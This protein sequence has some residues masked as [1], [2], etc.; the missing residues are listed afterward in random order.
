MKK[1]NVDFK[2]LITIWVILA[3][4]L[5]LN[6]AHY[7]QLI[8]DAGREA[9]LPTQVLLGKVLYKDIF[10]IYGPFAYMFNAFLFKIFGIH[11]KVL[12]F[13]GISCAFLITSL[14]YLI[15]KR[16]H[17]E[18]LS[19]S[20]ALFTI[21][22]GV[23]NSYLFN[24]VF[25]YSYAM[26][27]GLT[28]FLISLWFLL[29]Y[30]E[31]KKLP[32]LYL[33]CFFAGL[34]FINKYEFLP[35]LL[36]VFYA[37][38]KVQKLKFKEY[39]YVILS[40]IFVPAICFG[41]LFLQGLQVKDL[42]YSFEIIKKMTGTRTLKYFYLRQGVYPSWQLFLQGTTWTLS[43]AII[44]F[45]FAYGTRT[46]N[47]FVAV[48]L[49]ILSILAAAKYLNPLSFSMLPILILILAAFDFNKLRE[50]LPL[51]LLVSSTLLVSLKVFWGVITANYG[52]FFLSILL[53]TFLSLIADKFKEKNLNFKAFGYFIIV[54]AIL[55]GYK[56]L[57]PL[58][59]KTLPL[60]TQTG[61]FYPTNNLY[62]AT[63][64]L[65]DYIKQN[66]KKTDSVLILPE[67]A[68]INFLAQRPTDNFYNS[69]IPLYVETF[70]EDKIISHV[71]K[72][73]PE[74]IIF[75]NWDSKDYYLRYICKDY[76]V[77]FCN[78]VATNYTQEHVI[79][80]GFRYIIFKKK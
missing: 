59:A 26:L 32:F 50:N 49:V 58:Y 11:L 2:Y 47:K 23:A 12:Y 55:L 75:N 33:N 14:I 42:V 72:S 17:T 20:L 44:C 24:F 3:T 74:Y 37:I 79:D 34:C 9:Y 21:S 66:T 1:I 22:V 61:T 13:A 64:S 45:C 70:G 35:Y 54:L 60:K 77:S 57:L 8:L 39:Y 63:K 30:Q 6:Y 36:A 16:F 43:T 4:I 7:G 71:K 41:T 28:S 38:F 69:L 53:L 62:P 48:L 19:F 40:L 68:M 27:Y 52:V 76:A 25:P 18:Y 73:K 78:F 56:N 31:T 29:K 5:T 15:A 46:K 67:G 10:N 80:K 65:L 51:Q